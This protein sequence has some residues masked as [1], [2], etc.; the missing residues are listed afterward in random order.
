MS[1]PSTHDK[2]EAAYSQAL[3]LVAVGEEYEA[4]RGALID[5]WPTLLPVEINY[6]LADALRDALKQ[7]VEREDIDD[8]WF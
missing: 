3:E 8:S 7:G 2:I 5:R 6:T 1:I 4:A